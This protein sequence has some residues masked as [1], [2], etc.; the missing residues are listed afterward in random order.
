MKVELVVFNMNLKMDNNTVSKI[1]KWVEAKAT[2]FLAHQKYCGSPL[3][4]YQQK[5]TYD[6]EPALVIFAKVGMPQDVKALEYIF[7]NCVA[8]PNELQY[9]PQTFPSLEQATKRCEPYFNTAE[10]EVVDQHLLVYGIRGVYHLC[11]LAKQELA[12]CNPIF[13][14]PNI[15]KYEQASRAFSWYENSGKCILKPRAPEIEPHI[16]SLAIPNDFF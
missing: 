13:Q 5:A 15:W 1:M 6:V 2:Y 16:T 7:K 8:S 11:H 12:D 14:S 4:L 10:Y 9:C 3:K